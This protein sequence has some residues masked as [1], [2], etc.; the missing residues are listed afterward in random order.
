MVAVW[1]YLGEKTYSK[2][3]IL[4]LARIYIGVPR[5]I[6]LDQEGVVENYMLSNGLD[7]ECI[8]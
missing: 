7:Y 5:V 1:R 4:L 2:K 8:Q 3:A 6:K